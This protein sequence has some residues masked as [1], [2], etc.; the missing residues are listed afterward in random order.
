M[1]EDWVPKPKISLDRESLT[2]PIDQIK[3][4]KIVSEDKNNSITWTSSDKTVAEV[5]TNGLVTAL[6]EGTATITAKVGTVEST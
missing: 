5:D 1:L 6:K 4:I 2:L 3:K